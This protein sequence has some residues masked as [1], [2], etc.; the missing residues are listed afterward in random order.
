MAIRI[1]SRSSACK[2]ELDAVGAG[3]GLALM[4]ERSIT[5]PDPQTLTLVGVVINA[6]LTDQGRRDPRLT[7][8]IADLRATA[9]EIV[10]RLNSEMTA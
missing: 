5:T 2:P 1:S 8:Q 4:Q 9:Q 3:R 6:I 7:R 10:A